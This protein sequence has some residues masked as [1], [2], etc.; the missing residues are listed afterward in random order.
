MQPKQQEAKTEREEKEEIARALAPADFMRAMSCFFF[1]RAY[2][3]RVRAYLR[4]CYTHALKEAEEA[5][6]L[7]VMYFIFIFIFE[8]MYV[9]MHV[10]MYVRTYVMC[11]RMYACMYVCMY[12]YI[13]MYMN[14]YMHIYRYVYEYVYNMC[15]YMN[16][17]I[18][19]SMY[20]YI[21]MHICTCD[22]GVVDEALC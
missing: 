15:T 16:M 21:Y 2:D 11:V 4:T 3:T 12:A 7:P 13:C 17:N 20:I 6:C 10:C 1:P 19:I 8:C 22:D 5:T 9:C 18:I 14:M